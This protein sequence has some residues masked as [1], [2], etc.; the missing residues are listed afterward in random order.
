M[1]EVTTRNPIWMFE[2]NDFPGRKE[3]DPWMVHIANA[4][5][6][7]GHHQILHCHED[8]SEVFILLHGSCR[9]IVGGRLYQLHEGDVV[10]CNPGVMH[11]EFPDQCDF[12][13]TLAVGIGGL[14]IPG[15]HPGMLVDPACVP[16]LRKSEQ[17]EELRELC[18]MMMKYAEPGENRNLSFVH[19]LLT[20]S[21]EL[22]R[23]ILRNVDTSAREINPLCIAVE[24]YLDGHFGENITLEETAKLFFVSPWH[25]SR[26]F[27]RETSYN[28]K[29]YLLRLRL[30]EAQMRLSSTEQSI[31]EIAQACGFHDPAY[32]SRLFTSHIGISPGRYRR[33]RKEAE[34]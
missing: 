26:V 16:V 5:W 17:T 25:L 27:K 12:Y 1:T 13:E 3:S 29:Q 18:G 33:M 10:L 31:G 21:V 30:G 20:A 15:L 11:D 23:M 24:Q 19:L 28:F 34:Q 22:L 9:Y 7:E 4:D 14:S 2:K 6:T 8:F 32:F